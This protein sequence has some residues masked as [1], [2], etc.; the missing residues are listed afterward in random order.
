MDWCFEQESYN[1][2]K[3]H[4]ELYEFKIEF[5][6]MPTGLLQSIRDSALEVVKALK[7]KFRPK[8]KPW[9]M[10][11][12]DKRTVSLRGNQLSFSWSGDR[13]KQIIQIPDFFKKYA[14][15][16]FQA[17]T[18]G[19]DKIKKQFKINL[20]FQ[21][22][23]PEKKGNRIIGIDRGLYN[24]VSLSDGFK[25]ASNQIRKVKREVLFLKKQLQTKGTHSAKRRLKRCQVMRSGSV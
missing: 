25:Y 15:W 8:K 10:V 18:I 6:N 2:N 23:S 11:R 17:A 1:K 24:I 9:S 4:E 16:T 5:P 7:F 19:Y 21:S 14:G 3:A 12:Y 13:I 22:T 20:I